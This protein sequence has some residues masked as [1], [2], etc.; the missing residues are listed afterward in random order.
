MGGD[1]FAPRSRSPVSINAPLA[2]GAGAIIAPIR[3]ATPTALRATHRPIARLLFGRGASTRPSATTVPRVC[4]SDGYDDAS[5][6][7]AS[8]H[9]TGPTAQR[10]R[11]M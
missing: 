2:S 1:P 11:S 5:C 10:T 9:T 4:V 8:P 7:A 3:S 6:R